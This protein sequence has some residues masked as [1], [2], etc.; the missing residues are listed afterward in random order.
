VRL[1]CKGE[2]TLPWRDYLLFCVLLYVV[3]R[4]TNYLKNRTHDPWEWERQCQ[5]KE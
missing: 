4:N 5:R 3:V 1:Q 2:T